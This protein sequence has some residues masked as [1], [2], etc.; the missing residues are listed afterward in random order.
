MLWIDPG[1]SDR[2]HEAN[3]SRF[4]IPAGRNNSTFSCH[5]RS[6]KAQFR[7]EDILY[8]GSVFQEG[9]WEFRFFFRFLS[10]IRN[11]PGFPGN[12]GTRY[13]SLSTVLTY[14]PLRDSPLYACLFNW[15]ET[16]LTAA[17]LFSQTHCTQLSAVFL[18][19]TSQKTG[20]YSADKG[21]RCFFCFVQSFCSPVFIKDC[22]K[23]LFAFQ[24]QKREHFVCALS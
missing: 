10:I 18:R 14:D 21:F 8:K 1:M 15:N 22:D 20:L 16:H 6:W 24:A 11:I 2:Y 9:P 19:G 13:T 5:P 12:K 3:L 23:P 4:S 7:F 17:Y